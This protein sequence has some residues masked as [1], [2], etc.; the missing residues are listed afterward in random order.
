[1]ER[2]IPSAGMFPYADF[3][4][5]VIREA[6]QVD[7]SRHSHEFTELVLVIAGHGRHVSDLART[8]GAGDG[9]VIPVGA[10]HGYQETAGLEL[11]NVLFSQRR[12]PVPWLDLAVAPGWHVLFG[13]QAQR[14][15]VDFR[16]PGER[17][18]EATSLLVDLEAELRQRRG[19][20]QF[21]AM[22]RFM[23]LLLLLVRSI[24]LAP[25]R[26]TDAPARMG[27][28]IR[29]LNEHYAEEM[30]L[31]QMAGRAG[32]STRGLLRHFRNAT[33]RTPLDHL[34]RIRIAKAAELLL[35]HPGLGMGE[36]AARV[37]FADAN[38]LA[39]Q[40]RRIVGVTPT[41]FRRRHRAGR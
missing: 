37:G 23:R 13:G 20:Y 24:D 6:P 12:L 19:G 25:G 41:G 36:I 32:M 14:R 4:L 17:L 26:S 5:R 34:L 15:I 39:R 21:A 18:P 27:R 22:A 11:W 29:H 16:L 33:G 38:Y 7:T 28:L 10:A 8:I 9:F 2:V 31:V 40:F 1:M 35:G 30:T 3:P